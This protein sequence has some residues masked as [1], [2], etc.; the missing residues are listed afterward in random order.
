M[1]NNNQY[2]SINKYNSEDI[3]GISSSIPLMVL[4]GK[5]GIAEH[6]KNVKKNKHRYW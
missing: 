3:L 4:S 1:E 2:R 6:R 5:K